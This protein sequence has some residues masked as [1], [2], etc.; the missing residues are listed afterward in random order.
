MRQ[1]SARRRAPRHRQY[2]GVDSKAA[3]GA[4]GVSMTL[5]ADDPASVVC[6]ECGANVKRLVSGR[7]TAHAA[8]G[9]RPSI[10]RGRYKCEGS[11]TVV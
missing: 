6:T 10:Q 5:P 11:G 9:L 3:S 2:L 7:P 1:T 8:G 4:K